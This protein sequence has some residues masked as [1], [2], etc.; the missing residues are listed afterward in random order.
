MPSVV[1]I[2]AHAAVGTKNAVTDALSERL[3]QPRDIPK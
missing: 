2:F 3:P 1:Y